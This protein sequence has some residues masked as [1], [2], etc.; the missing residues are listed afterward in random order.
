MG[1]SGRF[2]SKIKSKQE[3][4]VGLDMY[5]WL[6]TL[7]LQWNREAE[8]RLGVP[9]TALEQHKQSEPASKSVST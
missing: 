7:I 2:L 4:P 8:V 3:Q 9:T 5:A 6:R 1:Q